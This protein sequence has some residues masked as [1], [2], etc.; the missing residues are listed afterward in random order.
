MKWV[1]M[2]HLAFL[3]FWSS[4][5]LTFVP[6][7]PT[8]ANQLFLRSGVDHFTSYLVP[9]VLLK[10]GWDFLILSVFVKFIYCE[11]ATKFCK[12]STAD[13]NVTTKDKSM[14]EISQKL[15]AFSEYMNLKYWTS[16][17]EPFFRHILS[18]DLYSFRFRDEIR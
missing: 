1:C 10:K 17:H 5:I 14:V 7:R 3:N 2:W 4:N 16:C 12:I 18:K 11:K 6:I 9:R 8:K 15:V 13:L